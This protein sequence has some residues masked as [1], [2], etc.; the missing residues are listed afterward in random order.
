MKRILSLRGGGAKG[1]A[2]VRALQ[3]LEEY[4]ERRV[5]DMFDLII[6]TSVGSI[7]GA[8]LA[9]G[10]LSAEEVLQEMRETLPKVFTRRR[11]KRAKYSKAPLR[12]AFDRLLGPGFTMGDV[13]TKLIITAHEMTE[14]RERFFKSWEPTANNG[15][16]GIFEA[17]DRSSAAPYYF[18]YVFA[19]E[20]SRVW[21]DGGVGIFNNPAM[22]GHVEAQRQGWHESDTVVSIDLG[23]GS[24]SRSRTP[25][26]LKN[27]RKLGQILKYISLKDGGLAHGAAMSGMSGLAEAE[28]VGEWWKP[29]TVE[30]VIP[31]HLDKMDNV[32]AFD[33]YVKIGDGLGRDL[34]SAYDSI[35]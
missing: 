24:A 33:E 15:Q 10:D 6:G 23:C 18:G 12:K 22:Y 30:A 3:W 4:T 17:V 31:E 14:D 8:L 26:D 27:D 20:G 32:K 16:L 7:N 21:S 29:F 25:S 34:I 35:V 28:G 19:D 13:K 5:C 9:S 11:F 2:Q 1:P